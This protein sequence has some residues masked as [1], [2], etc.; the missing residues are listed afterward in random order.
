MIHIYIYILKNLDA[1]SITKIR[2]F[3]IIVN[4]SLENTD[5]FTKRI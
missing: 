4:R 1:Q 5:K 3:S 2:S